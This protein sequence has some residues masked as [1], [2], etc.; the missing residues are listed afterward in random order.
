M[1]DTP[2]PDAPAIAIALLIFGL[3]CASLVLWLRTFLRRGAPSAAPAESVPAWRIGWV[4]FGLFL[5]LLVLLVFAAQQVAFLFLGGTLEGMEDGLTPWLAVTA[6]CLLHLPMLAA[7]LASRQLWPHLYGDR[8]NER[9]LS[10]AGA[11]R[12]A[13]PL[14]LRYLPLVWIASFLWSV[15]L[16][17]LQRT[18]LVEDVAPQELVV[19]FAAGGDP[20]AMVVLALLAVLLAPVVEELIFRGCIYR[21]LKSQISPF[22][23]QVA[24]AALFASLHA[25]LAAFFPLVLLG[26][27]L[28]RT[29]ERTGNLL[30]PILFHSLFNGFTLLLLFLASRS[31]MPG[32]EATP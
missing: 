4:N 16:A 24:S 6:V 11:L 23:A 3:L 32:L 18:G 27:L 8:L 10:V 14:F 2:S 31:S 20:V 22:P 29:Y 28:A 5:C 26:V 25:N 15:L 9:R 13:L 30:P 19:L 1:P 7:F 12:A 17:R 21:F